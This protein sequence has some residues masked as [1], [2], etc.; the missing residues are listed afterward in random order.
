MSNEFDHDPIGD[1][2][3]SRAL[4]SLPGHV[5]PP[6]LRTRLRVKASKER[7]RMLNR[8]TLRQRWTL[9]EDWIHLNVENV[10]RPMAL[11]FAGG[12][13]SAV[14]LFSMWVVPTYPVRASSTYDIP[15][16]LSTEA[17]I[18]GAN[19]VSAANGDIVIDVTV[20]DQGKMI[21]YKIVSGERLVQEQGLRRRLENMLLFTE[22]VPA[23][24]FG[25]PTAA[26]MRLSLHAFR[27]DV[28]G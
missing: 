11:P 5:P 1:E 21:D 9:V 28:K 22:F 20:D 25:R 17:E 14:V 26:R 7:Q 10:M 16:M 2:S 27:V 8:Q 3:L 13:F 18:K 12:V 19:P 23:T 4:R 6:E 15:T 24:S